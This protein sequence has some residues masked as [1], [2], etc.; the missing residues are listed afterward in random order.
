M[1]TLPLARASD[2]AEICERLLVPE[3]GREA[4]KMLRRVRA[5]YSQAPHLEEGMALL[6]RIVT[7]GSKDLFGLLAASIRVLASALGLRAEI[8]SSSVISADHTKKGEARVIDI[9]R[10]LG[11]DI[12]INPPG[13]RS[14]YTRSNFVDASLDLM[15]LEPKILPYKQHGVGCF[16]PDL[17]IIDPLMALGVGGVKAKLSERRIIA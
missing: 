1:L 4:E 3:F 7:Y 5:A 2:A 15:F 11:A 13:G 9:C 10:A 17:S 14:L 6:E 12:Y 16:V 8:I